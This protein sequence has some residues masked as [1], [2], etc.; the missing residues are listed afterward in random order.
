MSRTYVTAYLRP[1]AKDPA[2]MQ[3]MIVVVNEGDKPTREQFYV[4]QPQ[5]MFGGPN[6]V[7]AHAVIRGWDCS[8]IPSD[9]DWRQDVLIGSAQGDRTLPPAHLWD[10]EDNGFVRS[11]S[12]AGGMEIYGLLYV[13][14]RSFR[15]VYGSGAF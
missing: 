6:T 10:L 5:R 3:A 14:A 13:P 15:L 9:S 8:R 4:L 2:K 1:A 11:T 7:T 12:N